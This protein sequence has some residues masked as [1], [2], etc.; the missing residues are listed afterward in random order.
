[1]ENGTAQ[2]RK[3]TDY[4]GTPNPSNLE[5]WY[6]NFNIYQPRWWSDEDG[7]YVR[8]LKTD[9]QKTSYNDFE[10]LY[11]KYNPSIKDYDYYKI[12]D[13]NEDNIS[14]SND[15]ERLNEV[16]TNIEN[17]SVVF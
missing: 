16:D 7:M 10:I 4:I 3:I 5:E 11:I 12:T 17:N 1:M 15:S 9:E 8:I 6:T 2:K 14:E 13:V